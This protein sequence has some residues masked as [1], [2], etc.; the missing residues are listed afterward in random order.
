MNFFNN[1]SGVIHTRYKCVHAPTNAYTHLREAFTHLR[2]RTRTLRTPTDAHGR[3]QTP[4]DAHGRANTPC[5]DV[6]LWKNLPNL[7]RIY[8]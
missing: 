1:L 7:N 5:N 3:P 8:P 4:T 2:M 6:T